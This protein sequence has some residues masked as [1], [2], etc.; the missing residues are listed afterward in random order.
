LE[1]HAREGGALLLGLDEAG[2]LAFHIEK[3]VGEAE[4]PFQ[5]K[6][7]QGNASRGM[8]IG[9]VNILHGPTGGG[10]QTIDFLPGLLFVARHLALVS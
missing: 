5:R 10:E 7:A 4:A 1:F 2:G 9:G 6:F 3:V 8:Q